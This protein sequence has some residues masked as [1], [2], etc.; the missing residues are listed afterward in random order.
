MST[1]KV[2]A[3]V[4]ADGELH[5]KGLPYRKGDVVEATLQMEEDSPEQERRREEALQ[6]LLEIAKKSTFR[7]EGPYPTRDELHERR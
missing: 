2:Q 6:R 4:E 1:L 3:I 7:S 5:L